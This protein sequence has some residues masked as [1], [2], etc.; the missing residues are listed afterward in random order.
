MVEEPKVKKK[1]GR[2]PKHKIYN[3][4]SI[5]HFNTTNIDNNNI[6][7]HLP[8][9]LNEFKKNQKLFKK[10]DVFNYI[11]TLTIPNC[12]EPKKI[13]GM[14][15][16]NICTLDQNEFTDETQLNKQ[17]D[18][19]IDLMSELIDKTVHYIYHP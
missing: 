15:I 6:I 13:N 2:K 16:D 17:Y 5:K 12:M 1:R 18:V 7:I 9:K 14:I 4:G 3:M 19:C 8:I 11:P 10:N